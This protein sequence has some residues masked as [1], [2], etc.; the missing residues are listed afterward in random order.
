MLGG[1]NMT[2]CEKPVID[3]K[4]IYILKESTMITKITEN[5]LCICNRGS[6]EVEIEGDPDLILDFFDF[7]KKS[8]PLNIIC[9]FMNR[10]HN[11]DQEDCL[12]VAKILYENSLLEKKEI[13]EENYQHKKIKKRYSRQQSYFSLFNNDYDQSFIQMKNLMKAHVTLIGMG[14]IG[15]PVA[16]LL[17]R[18]GIKNIR[19]VD[20]DIV[21]LS[22]LNRQTLYSEKDIGRLKVEVAKERLQ[23]IDNEVKVEC[24]NETIHSVEQAKQ[25][26][27]N[28]DFVVVSADSPVGKLPMWINE[29]CVSKNVPVIF[30]GYSGDIGVVGPLIIPRKTLCLNCDEH[31]STRVDSSI[32]NNVREKVNYFDNKITPPSIGPICFLVSSIV[33][34]EIIKALAQLTITPITINK[35]LNIDTRS[36]KIDFHEIENAK[37]QCTCYKITTNN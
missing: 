13:S 7:L 12:E 31:F 18:A 25:V 16:D 9:A 2:N 23:T 37:N 5:S 3:Y 1:N 24:V 30:T 22:N 27:N 33:A 19:C 21:E 15:S 11:I 4:K 28:S 10:D 29:A 8:I 32:S 17:V 34:H 6:E 26:I 35:V 36:L 20:G 14:G